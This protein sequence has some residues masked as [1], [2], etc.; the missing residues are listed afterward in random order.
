M[1]TFADPSARTVLDLQGFDPA[2]VGV[3]GMNVTVD[4]STPGSPISFGLTWPVWNTVSTTER[5]KAGASQIR[6]A[7]GDIVVPATS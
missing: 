3:R 1:L 4:S 7:L 5:L 2:L 6:D